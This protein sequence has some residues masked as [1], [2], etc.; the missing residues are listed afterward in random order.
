MICAIMQPT[1]MPWLGYF[2]MIQQADSFVFLDHVQLVK[3]SWQVRNRIKG[4]DGEVMLTIPVKTNG[5]TPICD[6]M[7]DYTQTWTKKH[8]RA[9][10]CYYARAS[11]YQEV[12]PVVEAFYQDTECTLGT[13]H[14]RV[15]KKLCE[16]MGIRTTLYSSSQLE[17]NGTK[18]DLLADICLK[19]GADAYLSAQGSADYINRET[20]GGAFLKKNIDL[21]YFDYQ[22]P[23]YQ[24]QYN[25][26]IPFLG[27]YDLLFNVGFEKAL[28]IILSGTKKCIPY[29]EFFHR[30]DYT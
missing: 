10:Q 6:T 11:A 25:D 12:F 13:F 28:K 5:P 21:F 14:E 1:Y 24:Q 29:S 19:I 27:I 22:H 4:P 3:R 20:V 2:N 8:L 9:I 15:I 7:I 16:L 18:D 26:F 30:S 23:I 17:V